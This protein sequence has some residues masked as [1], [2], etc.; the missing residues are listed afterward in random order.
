MDLELLQILACPKCQQ[1]LTLQE[2]QQGLMCPKCAVVYPI[3]QEVPVLLQEE[4]ITVTDWN[5]GKRPAAE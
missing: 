4:A 2:D 5:Q 3:I 1:S